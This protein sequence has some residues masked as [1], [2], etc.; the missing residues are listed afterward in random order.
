MFFFSLVASLASLTV[1]Q[2]T[3]GV[4]SWSV[5][6]DPANFKDPYAFRPERWL[7]P[8][9]DNLSASQPF[10]LGTRNCIGQK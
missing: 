7:E 3:V 5:T 4:H 2:T 10:I 9:T 6:H 1:L 8:I